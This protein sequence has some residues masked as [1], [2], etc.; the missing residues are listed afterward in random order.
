MVAFLPRSQQQNHQVLGWNHN[1]HPFQHTDETEWRNQA[2]SQLPT[3]CSQILL[4]CFPYTIYN[5]GD[6]S[7]VPG[8]H[9]YWLIA[10]TSSFR[11]IVH[12]IYRRVVSPSETC[13]PYQGLNCQQDEDFVLFHQIGFVIIMILLYCECLHCVPNTLVVWPSPHKH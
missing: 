8:I 12:L 9:L 7:M 2:G 4:V 11:G 3:I 5:H 10:L 6:Q 1:S 13:L